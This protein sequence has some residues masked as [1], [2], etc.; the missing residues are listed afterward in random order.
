MQP[1]RR[2]FPG[3]V[4]VALAI[5][6]SVAAAELRRGL[7]YG[8]GLLLAF[9]VSLGFNGLPVSALYDYF[10]PFTA[11]RVPARMGLMV[12]FSLAVL[13]GYGAARLAGRLRSAPARRGA[14]G[15]LGVLMLVE[16]ASTPLPFWHAP[17][18]PPEIYT[19]LVR[20]RGDSPTAVLFEFP[21]GLI[22]DSAYR[23]LL[24]VPLAVADQRLQRILP[25]VV[26]RLV[27]AVQNFPDEPSI[28]AIKSHGVRYLVIH[29]EYLR[30]DRYKTL[31]PQLDQ[32]SD[33]TLVSRHPWATS[34][35]ARAEIS[36]YPVNYS[37][38]PLRLMGR[39]FQYAVVQAFRQR[40]SFRRR[41]GE[42]LACFTA[43]LKVRAA[44]ES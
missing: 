24:D 12:G 20:D 42:I 3:F 2:L 11:L 19:D 9:D 4:A 15:A 39:S 10:L 32:R 26:Y 30:G 29:G 28:D 18:Q 43:A 34:Y 38:G 21:T 6:G 35:Q 8:L 23:L 27:R 33:L 25:A 7:A 36:L 5:V 22:E 16:Y 17:R 14:L 37:R 41:A 40:F 31:I 1:E 13:A 44:R